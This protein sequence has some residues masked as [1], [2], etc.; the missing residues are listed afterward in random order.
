MVNEEDLARRRRIAG[1]M[2]MSVGI[3][4]LVLALMVALSGLAATI[5]LGILAFALYSGDGG[6]NPLGALCLIMLVFLFIALMILALILTRLS[7]WAQPY[8]LTY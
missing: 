8:R 7:P 1:I 5:G 6:D 4:N 2:S 3:P